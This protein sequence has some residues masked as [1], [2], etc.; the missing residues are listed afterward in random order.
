ML[1]NVSLQ[2]VVGAKWECREMMGRYK[3]VWQYLVCNNASLK[4]LPL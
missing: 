4:N 1:E 3:G 2:T